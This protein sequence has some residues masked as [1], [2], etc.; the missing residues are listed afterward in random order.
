MIAVFCRGTD[1][2]CRC[3]STGCPSACHQY[4]KI[5]NFIRIAAS[6]N[7]E[8]GNKKPKPSYAEYV[9]NT[10]RTRKKKR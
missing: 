6:T 2:S 7:K 5:D 9:H 8:Q 4:H 1:I 10:I 3:G